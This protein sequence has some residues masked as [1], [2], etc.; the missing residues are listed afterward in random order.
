MPDVTELLA[1]AARMPTGEPDLV[2]VE[3]R[4]AAL[5]RRQQAARGGAVLAAGLA[6]VLVAQV[7]RSGS[8]ALEQV[9]AERPTVTAS[10]RPE[11]SA[12]SSAGVVVPDPPTRVAEVPTAVEADADPGTTPAPAPRPS[13]DL[14]APNAAPNAAPTAASTAASPGYPSAASCRVDTVGLLAN[15]ERSC[16]FTATASGGWR[17]THR[18]GAGNVGN[19]KAYVD[20]TRSG[21]T[22]RYGGRATDSAGCGD[23][24]VQPGDLVTVTV[25]Q[26][27]AGYVEMEAAAGAGHGC[28]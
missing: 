27:D 8:D 24:V 7:G 12:A 4:A 14:A 5:R 28:S 17:V 1:A 3:R 18:Y 25:T 2:R 16:R 15:E 26:T 21:R 6:T 11:P 20:V 9:P 10:V 19:P 13:S 23:D 22:T